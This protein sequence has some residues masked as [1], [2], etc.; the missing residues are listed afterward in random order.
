MKNS[1]KRA[2]VGLLTAVMLCAPVAAATQ[3]GIDISHYD[4]AVNFASLKSSGHGEFVY[5]KSTEG[6]HTMDSYFT[7]NRTDAYSAGVPWG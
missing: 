2:A 3:Q 4:G 1:I 6:E 7:R 5:I